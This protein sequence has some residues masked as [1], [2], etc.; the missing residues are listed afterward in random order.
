MRIVEVAIPLADAKALTEERQRELTFQTDE[1]GE[2]LRIIIRI[3]EHLPRDPAQRRL[4]LN[5]RR[6]KP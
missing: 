6:R 2:P 5:E 1:A 4:P 3:R